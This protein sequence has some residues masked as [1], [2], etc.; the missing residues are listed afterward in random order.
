[1]QA[2]NS[3]TRYERA[4]SPPANGLVAVSVIDAPCS[5]LQG[6]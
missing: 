1:M 5:K 2:R 3:F 4:D 6:I